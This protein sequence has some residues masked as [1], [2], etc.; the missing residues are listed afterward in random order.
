MHGMV[1]GELK[2]FV[3]KKLGGDTWRTL[4]VE[5]GLPS[6]VYVPIK[7]YPDKEIFSLVATAS[8]LTG[9]DAPVILKDFGAFIAADLLLLFR[10]QI[11]K[12]WNVIDLLEQI[13]DTIH[14]VVRLRNPGAKPPQLRVE[15]VADDNVII[16]YT[17]SRR[18]CALGIGLIEGIAEQ[19][20]D[21][22]T[23]NEQTCML[24]GDTACTIDIRLGVP[25]EDAARFSSVELGSTSVSNTPVSAPNAHIPPEQPP[26]IIVGAGPVGI[27]AARRILIRRPDQPLVVYGA[28]PWEPYNRVRLSELLAGDVEWNEIANILETGD[29]KQDA[30]VRI[31]TQISRIDRANKAVIDAS[32]NRHSY[33]RLIIATG[34][35]A[36]RADASSKTSLSGIY[37]Y[38]DLDD[39]QELMTNIVQSENTVVSGGGVL[40]IEVAFALKTQNPDTEVTILHKRDRLM[41][42]Q[43]EE[44]ASA[45]LLEQVHAARI[46][47][48]LNTVVSE[49]IGD[50]DLKTIR[51][52]NGELI[53]CDT[54]ISCPGIIANTELAGDAGLDI[55]H[56]IKVNDFLQTSDPDIYA[57]GE[58][59]EHRGKTAG[60][61]GPGIEQATI[62]VDN[63]LD[64]NP[65][66][67]TGT[68]YSMRV[69]IKHLPIF[70][71]RKTGLIKKP[72]SKL[73]FE[74][75][76][77]NRFREIMLDRGRLVGAT[78]I[79]EWPEFAQVQEALDKGM[80]VHPWHRFYFAR[81]GSLWP[82][83]S[84]QDPG[85][86]AADTVVCTCSA[87]TRGE[88]GVAMKNGCRSL[89]DLSV[90]TGASQ[91]CGSCRPLLEKLLGGTQVTAVPP[92]RISMAV[93][94]VIALVL[95]G[96]YFLPSF[97]VPHSI[98]D[99]NFLWTLIFSNGWRQVTGY[100][101]AG[102]ILL[103]LG[104][105]LHKHWHLLQFATYNTWRTVHTA[106]LGLAI[107][108]L[109][110]HTN[111]HW[112]EN[113][114][115]KLQTLF[116][117]TMATGTTLSALV[118]MEAGFFGSILRRPRLLFLRFH[119]LLVWSF[120]AM[121]I[122]HIV[123]VYYF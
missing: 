122:V 99:Q 52:N 61:L 102:L 110:L 39:A 121:L 12:N 21:P 18:M 78:A 84:L 68:N 94:T 2:K 49:F 79:G 41:N 10:R 98:H 111:M 43:L 113:F 50:N 19:F 15:R 59:A 118:L 80:R 31:N 14:N 72:S 44:E 114:N 93:F 97:P 32:G 38:R 107:A 20:G 81:T 40:G 58:C 51:L 30:Q 67:Y 85:D 29:H 56:G 86:W 47:V 112:G 89:T 77:Q 28:E 35:R 119:I 23:V 36:Q 60:L 90:T 24:H 83:E 22:V 65:K 13:E 105:S 100:T 45:F 6:R 120:F 82:P 117:I 66:Y 25:V 74:D 27:H 88:L 16:H 73:V 115:L 11:Q 54:L 104:L 46:K 76:E 48:F 5:A 123:S 64:G 87:V 33:S 55:N 1:F 42:K 109:L 4:L 37:T 57:I 26:I 101:T 116:F 63:I 7:V 62:A 8:R 96:G 108:V 106:V 92:M 91:G 34:S 69:K 53:P 95:L 3:D 70:S 75:P 17:S 9:L 103:S 71:L